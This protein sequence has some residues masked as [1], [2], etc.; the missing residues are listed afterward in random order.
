MDI[1]V[2]A[3][4]TSMDVPECMLIQ[5][6]Q[7]ATA[8]DEHLQWLKCFII[9]GWPDSKDQPH[10]DIRLFWSFRDDMAMIDGFIMKGRHIVIPDVLKPQ[11]LDKLHINHVGI[12]K[13]ILV[14]KSIYWASINN[15]IENYIKTALHVL[16]FSKHNPRRRSYIMTSQ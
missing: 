2:D 6:I 11:A 9:A 12:E 4:H 15:D 14:C 13:K 16:C 1:G 8:Q 7:Q 3:V 10:Q 5:Q